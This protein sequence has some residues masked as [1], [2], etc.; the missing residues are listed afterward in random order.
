MVPFILVDNLRR[1][2]RSDLHE[3]PLHDH[4]HDH[5]NGRGAS[6]LRVRRAVRDAVLPRPRLRPNLARLLPHRLALRRRHHRLPVQH[7][8]H[9]QS[10][11]V[12]LRGERQR[13]RCHAN[14][15][16]GDHYEEY[17]ECGVGDCGCGEHDREISWCG[18][19]GA[20]GGVGRGVG[21]C[22]GGADGVA[23]SGGH[24][25]G[26]YDVY[27][28]AWTAHVIMAHDERMH[29]FGLDFNVGSRLD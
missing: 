8:L 7:R 17:G 12:Q 4:L 1:Y 14:C 19:E 11:R 26:G 21:G 2:L 15:E 27:V 10:R 28:V 29:E 18:D 6:L 22:A 23:L 5:R 20:V 13:R 3:N 16:R 24:G 9:V 25:L